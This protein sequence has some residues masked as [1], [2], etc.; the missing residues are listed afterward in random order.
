MSLVVGR[1]AELDRGFAAL[2]GSLVLL[3]FELFVRLDQ[4]EGLNASRLQAAVPFQQKRIG[5]TDEMQGLL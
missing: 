2:Q 4:K 3:V 1:V 5:L